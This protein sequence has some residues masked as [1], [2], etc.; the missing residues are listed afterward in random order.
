M[1]SAHSDLK[2]K[3]KHELLEMLWLFLYLAFFFCA[4]VAYDLFL[5][6]EYAIK[7]WNFGFAVLNALVI[8]KVI[9]IGEYAR[10]GTRHENKGVLVSTFW[11]AIIFGLLVFVF[12]VV[13]EIVKRLLH[14]SDLARASGD[15]RIDRM[16]GRAIIVFCTFIPLFAFREFR[17]VMGHDEFAKLVFRSRST[18]G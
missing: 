6:D 10:L 11:K 16:A 14:G 8:T 5:L 18:G 13:E 15:L 17:R 12:H 2:Q 7:Y 4:L 1:D 3:A 9:M